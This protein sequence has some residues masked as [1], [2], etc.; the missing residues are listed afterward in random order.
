MKNQLSALSQR[1]TE[2]M[3][4][5]QSKA[6]GRDLNGLLCY[7]DDFAQ[8]LADRLDS[9]TPAEKETFFFSAAVLAVWG[10]ITS[11]IGAS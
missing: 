8:D 1:S 5:F 10:L 3:Q 11:V 7:A 6:D 9:S 2:G 4:Q